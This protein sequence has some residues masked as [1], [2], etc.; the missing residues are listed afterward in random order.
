[1]HRDCTGFS[2]WSST[3]NI[4]KLTAIALVK[5]DGVHMG[6]TGNVSRKQ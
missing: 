2:T 1:M 3:T 4:Y 5:L 6:I